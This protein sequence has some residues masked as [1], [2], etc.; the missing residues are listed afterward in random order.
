MAPEALFGWIRGGRWTPWRGSAGRCSKQ[1]ETAGTCLQR[2]NRCRPFVVD[3]PVPPDVWALAGELPPPEL[4]RIQ[5]GSRYGI[6]AK[7]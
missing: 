6:T 4:L 3:P 1:L 5:S 2:W 7:G